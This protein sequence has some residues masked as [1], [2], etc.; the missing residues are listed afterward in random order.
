M[1]IHVELITPEKLALQEEVD[2]LVAPAENG[3][4]GILANHAPLLTKLTTGELRLKKGDKVRYVAISGGFMEVKAG[5][6]VSVFA[7]TA[8]FAEDIDVERAKMAA[9]K[10]KQTLSKPS[11]DLTAAE[12]AQVEL[13]LNRALLRM[14]IGQNRWRKLPGDRVN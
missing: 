2:F 3:E 9:E 4:V 1:T 14:K 13:A 8:E 6:K 5:S 7:E 10:A 12:L 11:S